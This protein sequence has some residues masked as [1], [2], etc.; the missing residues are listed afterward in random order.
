MSEFKEWL[1]KMSRQEQLLNL[2]TLPGRLVKS[3]QGEKLYQLLTDFDFIKAN[4]ELWGVQPLIEDYDLAISSNLLLWPEQT[5]ILKLI[6]GAIRK[7]AQVLD[8]DKTQLVGQLLGR[9]LDFEDP[10]IQGLLEQGRQSKDSVWLR[11]LRGNLERPGEG[12]LQ[13]LTG[14]TSAVDAVAI[15]PDGL[16]AISASD[17]KTLKIWDIKTGKELLTLTGHTGSVSAVAIAPD[18][19]TAISASYDTTLKIW[20]IK[21]G[22]ELLTLTGRT[23]SLCAVAIAPDGLTAISASISSSWNQ[24]LKIWDIKTGTELLTLTGHSKQVTAV[25]IAPDSKTAIS[26]SRD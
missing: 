15:A 21:T 20:D 25:A 23:S 2:E 4:L 24:T 17:D 12:C 1:G 16:T 8:K 22:T 6:Q 10:D 5:E 11:P 19:K 18:G 9:L 14:H 26:A 13:T 7:S 3:K